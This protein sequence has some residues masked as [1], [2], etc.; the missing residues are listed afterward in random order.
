MD[1][2]KEEILN[3]LK[4]G[5]LSLDILKEYLG[6]END[7][8]LNNALNDLIEEILFLSPSSSSVILGYTSL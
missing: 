1:N 4:E 8:E 6:I 7:D 3:A 2:I 5:N